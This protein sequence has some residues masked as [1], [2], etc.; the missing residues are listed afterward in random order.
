MNDSRDKYPEILTD[1]A[2]MLREFHLGRGVAP[3]EAGKLAFEEAE[4]L[5]QN[6]GGQLVYIPLGKG[7][8]ALKR[9]TEIWGKFTGDNVPQ[10]AAEYKVSE[11]YVYQI[12]RRMRE[13]ERERVQ[14]KLNL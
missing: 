1:I 5:R 12:I 8:E 14:T 9:W 6:L 11:A 4:V 7:H 2:G 3:D 13:L 10:L